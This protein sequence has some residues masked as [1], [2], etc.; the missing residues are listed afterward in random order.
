LLQA[1]AGPASGSRYRHA[2]PA[3]TG[4]PLDARIAAMLDKAIA[5]A[6]NTL[7]LD[8]HSGAAKAM[9][10]RARTRQMDILKTGS[11]LE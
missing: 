5:T 2:P 3:A 10:A 1:R 7:D 11:S 8:P 9:L 4:K 6:E